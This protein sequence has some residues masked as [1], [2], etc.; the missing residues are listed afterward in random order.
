MKPITDSLFTFTGLLVGRVYAVVDSDGITLIDAGLGSAAGKILRQLEAAG[1]SASSVK[2]ILVT[3]AHPDHVGGLPALVA[4]TGAAVYC[5]ADE[6]PYTEG[7]TP[8]VAADPARLSGMA[9]RMA[10]GKP[11]T[12]KGVPVSHAL[13]DG[14]TIP[15]VF[16]GRGGLQAIF[17][18]GHSPGHVAYW[19]PDLRLVITGDV[20]MHLPPSGMHFRDGQTGLGLPFPAFTTDMEENRRSV[21]K[22][23]ALDPAIACFGHGQPIM[24]GAGE[25]IRTF[26]A[27]A[28]RSA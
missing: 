18:P 15:Q 16:A 4:A 2:R 5:G 20:M 3:H 1:H 10:S 13:T 21:E 23:G 8:I 24:S 6:V 9:R 22:I 19:Q 28:R 17:T 11:T 26:A 7:R 14:E 27:A 25:Q 12:M